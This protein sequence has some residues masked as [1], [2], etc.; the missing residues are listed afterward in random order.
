MTHSMSPASALDREFLGLRS[1][2]IDLAA[3][4]DRIDRTKD[5]V[6]DDLRRTQ[7]RRSLE[8]LLANAGNRAERIQAEFSLPYN[9]N[10]RKQ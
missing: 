9:E 5:G 1:R 7:V 10:W 2:L 3:T 8:I 4:L 6:D